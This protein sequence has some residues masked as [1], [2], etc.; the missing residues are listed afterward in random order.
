MKKYLLA[1]GDLHVGSAYGLV[2]PK[3]PRH[4]GAGEEDVERVKLTK[5]QRYLWR[6]YN[7][8]LNSPK[9]PEKI[10]VVVVNGDVIQGK[11]DPWEFRL[12]LE[13]LDDQRDHAVAILKPLRERCERMYIVMG[14]RSHSLDIFDVE[15]EIALALNAK[16][17]Y[18]FNIKILGKVFNFVHSRSHAYVYKTTPLS[19]E[20]SYNALMAEFKKV[21][22]ADVIVRSHIHSLVSV[23]IGRKLAVFLPCWQISSE[24]AATGRAS[25]YGSQPDIG[26]ILFEI[27]EEPMPNGVKLGHIFDYDYPKIRLKV[28]EV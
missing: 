20:I 15:R 27:T 21:P 25:W 3:V 24:Y 26:A 16:Y 23:R 8:M 4:V 2:H 12:S 14:T 22:R 13:R 28:E 6:C 19:R 7:H 18:V 1:L 11:R 9:L 17:H 10:D 5:I